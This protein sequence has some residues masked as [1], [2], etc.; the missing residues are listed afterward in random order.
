MVD[1]VIT[2]IIRDKMKGEGLVPACTDL[3]HRLV[4]SSHQ[5]TS[6]P[7]ILISI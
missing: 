1:N 3:N 4:G 5:K 2:L 7:V 6:R